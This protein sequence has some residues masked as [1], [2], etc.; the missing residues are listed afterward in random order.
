[1]TKYEIGAPEYWWNDIFGFAPTNRL[2]VYVGV[3]LTTVK[4]LIILSDVCDIILMQ[5]SFVHK[6]NEIKW[7]TMFGLR[8]LFNIYLLHCRWNDAVFALDVQQVRL[9][10]ISMYI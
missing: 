1:M 6:M 2:Y 4:L 7:T 10:A 9:W 8:L 5:P 3:F